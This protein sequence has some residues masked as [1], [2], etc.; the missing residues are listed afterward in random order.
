MP[1]DH[2]NNGDEPLVIAPVLREDVVAAEDLL[3]VHPIVAWNGVIT[4]P[5]DVAPQD[6]ANDFEMWYIAC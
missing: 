3:D 6:L 1:P 4:P 2:I 5:T